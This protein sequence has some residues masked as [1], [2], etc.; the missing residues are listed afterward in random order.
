MNMG[1]IM[2][3]NN[4][5]RCFQGVKGKSI[6]EHALE[7]LVKTADNSTIG[8]TL[9]EPIVEALE[10]ETASSKLFTFGE[11]LDVTET[12]ISVPLDLSD[13]TA[14][15]LAIEQDRA[16]QR[17]AYF[18]DM[19][20]IKALRDQPP[21]LT[22]QCK[23][24][25]Q[26]FDRILETFGQRHLICSH[27]FLPRILVS[28]LINEMSDKIDPTCQREL[29]MAGF[30][31]TNRNVLL[32]TTAGTLTFEIVDSN[33]IVGI[34]NTRCKEEIVSPF[35]CVIKE[36]KHCVYFEG[37]VKFSANRDGVVW[38]RLIE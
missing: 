14:A 34:D 4:Q 27:V 3:T 8:G 5:A 6:E 21:Q 1:G 35:K 33:E 15:T 29:V 13:L 17:L 9:L 38:T 32:V 16:R 18:K 26:A 12:K 19:A 37:S 20:A 10:C 31:G 23:T 24:F 28:D 2:S 25:T 7:E 36:D 30:L 22:Q 11:N